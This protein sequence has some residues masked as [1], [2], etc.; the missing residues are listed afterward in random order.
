[1]FPPVPLWCIHLCLITSFSLFFFFVSPTSL[2]SAHLCPPCRVF[3]PELPGVNF[4]RVIRLPPDPVPSAHSL[5]GLF[6]RLRTTDALQ[7]QRVSVR[8]T[9]DVFLLIFSPLASLRKALLFNFNM[10]FLFSMMVAGNS[11]RGQREKERPNLVNVSPKSKKDF[12]E[13]EKSARQSRRLLFTQHPPRCIPGYLSLSVS[14]S[15]PSHPRLS[16]QAPY[17]SP[18]QVW[19]GLLITGAEIYLGQRTHR[20]SAAF[21]VWLNRNR[22]VKERGEGRGRG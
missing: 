15:C 8:I 9:C 7:Y 12:T 20:Q 21:K 1:M 14:P 16:Y 10:H 5:S 18:L 13:T 11:C 4:H 2:F 3:Q 19:T 6:A 22:E 17:I